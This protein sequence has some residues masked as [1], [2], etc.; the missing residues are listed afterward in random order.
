M[1]DRLDKIETIVNR[2]TRRQNKK[3]K[4]MITPYP[5]STCVSGEDVEGDILKYMFCAP[6]RIV[7]GLVY[8]SA[9]PKSG[10]SISIRIDNDLGG[11]TKSYIITRKSLLVEPDIVISSGDRL[12]ISF[13]NVDE[14]EKITE[15]WL[16][17][18]WIPE[19]KDVDIKNFLIDELEEEIDAGV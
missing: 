10:A 9:K 15:L 3:M 8:L 7:K 6:G 5:I 2:L 18:M 12:T 1:T 17:F 19:I 14:V 13:H 16:A 11:S 4:A